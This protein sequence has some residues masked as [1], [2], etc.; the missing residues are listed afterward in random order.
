MSV[1]SVNALHTCLTKYII[2]I[3]LFCLN[4]LLLVITI[5]LKIFK[6]PELKIAPKFPLIQIFSFYYKTKFKPFKNIRDF[7]LP[8]RC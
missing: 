7:W 8:P 5:V 4:A 3:R 1:V 6:L 2:I